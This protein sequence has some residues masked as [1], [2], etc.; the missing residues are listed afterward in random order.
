MGLIVPREVFRTLRDSLDGSRVVFTNGCF[1][2]VHAGHLSLLNQ[3]RALGDA[4]VVGLNSDASVRELKGPGR[5]VVSQ[6]MRARLLAATL[7]VDF[8]II[9]DELRADVTIEA[10]RPH[11][12][13]K[14]GDYTKDQIPEV[15]LVESLGGAVVT[16]LHVPGFSTTSMIEGM[17]HG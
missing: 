9:Y 17:E 13:V 2:L 7:S 4:L 16:G 14:G 5:P 8:V 15:P 11:I 3:A 1:D 12:Y 10:V 6:D